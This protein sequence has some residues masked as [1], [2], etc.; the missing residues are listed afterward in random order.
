[1]PLDV[2]R[3]CFGDVKRLCSDNIVRG[4]GLK[5]CMKDNMTQL[6][7]PC[8]EALMTVATAGMKQPPD[9]GATATNMRFDDLRGVNYCEL[10]FIYAY[11]ANETLYTEMWN[12]SGLNNQADPKNTCPTDVWAKV[13]PAALTKQNDAL[14]VWKNGPRGWTMDWIDLPVGEVM[15]FDGWQGRWFASP[16][17]PKGVDPHVPG[18]SAYKPLTVQRKSVMT[19]EKGKPVF[20]LD[21]PEGT[22]WVMQA[23]AAIVDPNLTYDGLQTLG[24]KLKLAEGWKFRVKVLDEDLTI[25]AVNGVARLVQDDLENSYDACFETACT[26]KP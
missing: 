22:P 17:L 21:D 19:F 16:T 24:S 6:S 15:T 20:I 14:G 13:D 3:S 8:F 4:E 1:M 26:Y 7:G 25:K 12:S 9:Y 23:F 10:N 5:S 18:S 11:L 2:V